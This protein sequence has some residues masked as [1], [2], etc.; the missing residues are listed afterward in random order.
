[1][2][3]G[4]WTVEQTRTQVKRLPTMTQRFATSA[5]R[6]AEIIRLKEEGQSNHQIERETG[7]PR[8]TVQR[9]ISPGGAKATVS[10]MHPPPDDT[11]KRPHM[12]RK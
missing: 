7:I 1:M 5:A 10:Q 4:D 8:R 12:A 6:N 2:V 3:T 9:V 11:R